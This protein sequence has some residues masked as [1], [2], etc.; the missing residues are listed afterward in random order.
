MAQGD[1][2]TQRN[3]LIGRTF[4]DRY[5]IDAL[6]GRGGMGEVYQARQLKLNQDVALKV[7][8]SH[9]AAEE[10]QVERFN[11]EAM[12]SS[13]LKHP[14]SIRV[15]D[16]GQADDGNLFLAM[17]LLEGDELSEVIRK[18]SPMDPERVL[19]IGR[20]ILKSLGEAHDLGLIHR[21]LKPDNIFICQFY[22][23][24]DF[25]KVL[26]FGIAKSLE[27][28]SPAYETNP[29]L[30][31]GT[32][33]YVAP[34]Q[35]LGEGVTPQTDLYSFG[36]L[37]FEMLTGAPPFRA[38]TRVAT[39]MKQIHDTPPTFEDVLPGH[40]IPEKLEALVH[41]LLSKD[42]AGRPANSHEV[43]RLID[44]IT[45]D[46][47]S[48]PAQPITQEG[49]AAPVR[50]RR[51]RGPAVAFAAALLTIAVVLWWLDVIPGPGR[52]SH[53]E[54]TPGVRGPGGAAGA[55]S[56][57]DPGSDG[58]SDKAGD[59]AQSEPAPRL[60][61]TL[62]VSEPSGAEVLEND[63][64]LGFTPMTLEGEAG[65]VHQLLLRRPGY[66]EATQE[67]TLA[68]QEGAPDK[69]TVSLKRKRPSAGTKKASPTSP[70]G[71]SKPAPAK[72]KL[73]WEDF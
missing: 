3:S 17:E 21:D 68:L 33:L 27:G 49:S 6:V 42:P 18:D 70:S 1:D 59:D 55:A 61:R 37:L 28:P 24:D 58:P 72:E 30:V 20:Q 7:L 36:V 66:H 64:L 22:G 19:H 44:E 71:S 69:V 39:V 11:R 9:L 73:Q 29:A 5:R 52:G 32:P 54:L 16:Y 34:E 14:N 47:T 35:A 13:Q 63:A 31:C 41:R 62:V 26:D 56:Q 60:A 25:V 43:S 50:R 51:R 8:W 57:A 40:E 45:S 2:K 15:F 65:K 38:E 23:E 46:L 10:R 12:I 4:V 67:V 53:F 48:S